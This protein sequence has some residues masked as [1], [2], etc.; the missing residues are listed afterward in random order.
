MNK[1]ILYSTMIMKVI[2][3]QQLLLI[4]YLDYNI[5]LF[6]LSPHFCLF[7]MQCENVFMLFRKILLEPYY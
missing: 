6:E 3:Q 4:N 5:I 2:S 7:H 1:Y